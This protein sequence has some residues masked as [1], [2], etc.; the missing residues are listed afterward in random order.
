[1]T[2]LSRLERSTFIM[3]TFTGLFITPTRTVRIQFYKHADGED[4]GVWKPTMMIYGIL[5]PRVGKHIG[6]I[7]DDEEFNTFISSHHG[8][9]M[10]RNGWIYRNPSPPHEKLSPFLVTSCKRGERRKIL[11]CETMGSELCNVPESVMGRYE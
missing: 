9:E 4:E 10:L 3:E 7:S 5:T 2:H 1:M 11:L 8:M 6:F